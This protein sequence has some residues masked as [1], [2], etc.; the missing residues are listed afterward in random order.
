MTE[1]HFDKLDQTTQ[2]VVKTTIEESIKEYVDQAKGLFTADSLHFLRTKITNLIHE[3]IGNDQILNV[4]V[5]LDLSG[6]EHKFFF[7]V[8]ISQ[9]I[10]DGILDK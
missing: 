10:I 4:D 3:K 9:A 5:G 8:N 6:P 2:K 1:S 7:K